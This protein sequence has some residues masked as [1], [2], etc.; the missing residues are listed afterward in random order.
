MRKILVPKAAWR[1]SLA[2]EP[3]WVQAAG[4]Q[5]VHNPESRRIDLEIARNF[6]GIPGAPQRYV[7]FTIPPPQ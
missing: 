7:I 2:N 5:A 1:W 4:A 3:D 6:L